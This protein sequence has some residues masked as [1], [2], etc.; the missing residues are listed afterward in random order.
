MSVIVVI[1]F[2][3]G[4][5]PAIAELVKHRKVLRPKSWRER[6]GEIGEKRERA[7]V[8]VGGGRGGRE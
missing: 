4:L 8:C 7:G 1:Y 6:K 3:S 5:A 2:T